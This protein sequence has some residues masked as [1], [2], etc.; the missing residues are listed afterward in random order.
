MLRQDTPGV[1][2][3]SI[4]SDPQGAALALFKGS[5]S[6]GM[7]PPP[8]PA[9]GTP[10]HIGWHELHTTSLDGALAFC[11]EVFAWRK[12]ETLD[13]GPNG[14]YPLFATGAQGENADGGMAL[15]EP[16]APQPYRRHSI[17]VGSVDTSLAQ[18]TTGGVQVLMGPHQVPGGSWIVIGRDPQV[19]RSRWWAHA[20]RGGPAVSGI[21][22]SRTPPA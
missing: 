16:D 8:P 5:P 18:I 17:N 1:G 19:R 13:M 15:K 2:H 6:E 14:V 10:G 21:T 4:V 9:A 20:E 22:L 7:E 12:G 11:G 3:F